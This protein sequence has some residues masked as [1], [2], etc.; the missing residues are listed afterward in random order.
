MSIRLLARVW[1]LEVFGIEREVLN[2]FC[3]HADDSGR[4]A[5]PS[6]RYIAWKVGCDERTVIRYVKT[7]RK[8]GALVLVRSARAHA[9]N[10]YRVDL[11]VYAEKP[12]FVP[13]GDDFHKRGDNLSGDNLSG[14]RTVSPKPSLYIYKNKGNPLDI[15]QEQQ[16]QDALGDDT[17][18]ANEFE[19]LPSASG[20]TNEEL[21]ALQG[22]GKTSIVEARESLPQTLAKAGTNAAIADPFADKTKF[23]EAALALM[24]ALCAEAG[25]NSKTRPLFLKQAQTLWDSRPRYADDSLVSP[26]TILN[27]LAAMVT[28][29]A[30][31]KKPQ[32]IYNHLT[33][34]Y[35]KLTRGQTIAANPITRE[36]ASAAPQVQKSAVDFLNS[37]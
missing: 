6:I 8:K 18:A 4:N 7:L 26:Q 32:F 1:E 37:L 34:A 16:E 28:Q 10:E 15:T 5:R 14:D 13:K 3:D 33:L 20:R 27:D 17:H 2:A 19:S 25:I 35:A 29:R 11:S 9:P 30:N 24:P 12:P 21:A 31:L 22:Q 23:V 36:Q